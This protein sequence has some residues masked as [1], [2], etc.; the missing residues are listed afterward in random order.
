MFKIKI[1][2]YNQML[3]VNTIQY[4]TKSAGVND[5]LKAK[6]KWSSGYEVQVMITP[7]RQQ[8]NLNS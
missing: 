2:K 3:I 6:S 5:L 7:N 8:P 4:L 1:K